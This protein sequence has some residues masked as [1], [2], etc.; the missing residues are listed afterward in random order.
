MDWGWLQ[1]EL[2]AGAVI[3]GINMPVTQLLLKL[4]PASLQLARV[5]G[6]LDRAGNLSSAPLASIAALDGA[7]VYFSVVIG[8]ESSPCV[9]GGL[10][11]SADGHIGGL[12][13]R[14]VRA[15]A[16]ALPGRE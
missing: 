4:W 6:L 5:V 2:R 9:S 1:E 16:C 12:A 7:D 13:W 15:R 3:V 14:L 8:A 11:S 10:V